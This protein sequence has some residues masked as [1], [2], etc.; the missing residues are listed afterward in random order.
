MSLET[1]GR[2]QLL[3]KLATGGMAQIYLARQVGPEGF[4]K[5][6]VVK[7]ILPHLA[8]NDDFIT[9]F[10]DEARIAARLNHP[11][12]VQ[13][14]DLGAQ[15]DSYF[16]A[17]EFI[18]GEDVRRVWKHAERQGKPIPL[19]LICRIII[20]ACAG[21]DYAHKK[22]DQSGRP[23]GIVHRDI[24]PQNILVSFEGGVKVVDFGIA[25]AADQATVTRS[26]VLKGKYSYMS[27]E[28][29]GGQHIDSRTD[30]F[31]LGVVLYELLTGTRLFKRATDIQ[32]L[33][34]VTECAIAPPSAVNS[35]LPKDLD[36]IVMRALA[37]SRD[38]RFSEARELAHEL[39]HWLLNNKMP[40]SSSA[41][42]AFMHDA[43]SER[44]AREQEEGRLLVETSD[45]SRND[46]LLLERATPTGEFKSKRGN[47]ATQSLAKPKR[48]VEVTTA[49]RGPGRSGSISRKQLERALER[50]VPQASHPTEASMPTQN[51]A[52]RGKGPLLAAISLVSLVVIGVLGWLLMQGSAGKDALLQ[53]TSEPSD[54]SVRLGDRELCRTPCA[55][56]VVAPGDVQL[57]IVK[58]GYVSQ[59]RQVSFREG[60]QENLGEVKLVKAAVEPPPIVDTPQPQIASV[61]FESMPPGASLT[62]NGQ[63]VGTTPFSADFHTGTSL[64]VSVSLAGYVEVEDRFEVAAAAEP[65]RYVLTAVKTRTPTQPKPPPVEVKPLPVAGRGTVRFVVK[66]WA[67]VE[68]PQLRFKDQTPFADQQLPAGE[69]ACTFTNPDYPPQTR[70]VRVEPNSTTK[71]QVN[72]LQ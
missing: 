64:S 66:P 46:D 69:Y 10:L 36:G 68:C 33:N 61:K 38:D 20:D 5:L 43:Y 31:A 54:A 45:G 57:A 21:L 24:S 51:T 55:R 63:P 52:G 4:E 19:A 72:F 9:M 3:K 26:G 40:S 28:Q 14:F 15:D 56:V 50:P 1:Y 12:I 13:I 70:V 27:P 2:Y 39:E 16:I 42:A 47:K 22:T 37:K 35:R 71:V 25:K 8:E 59:T 41:L 18:H 17:M 67:V 34:A 53:L 30:I 49:E 6:L 44:L 23:L 48:D 32:T 7:R 11:N 62:I 60:V 58:D 65:R 29:A